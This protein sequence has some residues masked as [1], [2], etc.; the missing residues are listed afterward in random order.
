MRLTAHSPTN[1]LQGFRLST[2]EYLE[3][4]EMTRSFA[5]IGAFSVG[6]GVRA[7]ARAAGPVRSISRP[8]IARCA[9]APR[10]WTN[11]SSRP[12]ACSPNGAGSSR[13]ARPMP[14]SSRARASGGH[15][16]RSFRT[17][18]GSRRSG[19]NHRRPNRADRRP[20][21]RHHRDHAAGLRRHGQSDG[22]LA[23]D[24]HRTPRFDGFGRTT[25]SKSIGR[26]KDG[27]TPQ[28]AEAELFHVP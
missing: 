11:I 20:A 3:F 28:A 16:S 6:D 27:V 5:D 4:R 14:M 26:L 21:A 8:A 7:A 17:N 24:R 15:R 2:P 25:F 10:W 19:D 23:A 9:S 13:R 1:P 18:C 22:N 12:S